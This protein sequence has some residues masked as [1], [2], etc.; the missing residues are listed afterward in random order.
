MNEIR[1][2]VRCQSDKGIDGKELTDMP[3]LPSIGDEIKIGGDWKRIVGRAVELNNTGWDA[4][5]SVEITVESA[6]QPKR[7]V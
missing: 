2:K 5:S 3:F 4:T 7:N 1:I 6:A